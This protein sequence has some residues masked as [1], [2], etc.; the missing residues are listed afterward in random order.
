MGFNLHTCYEYYYAKQRINGSFFKNVKNIKN[1]GKVLIFFL[2][3]VI[4]YHHFI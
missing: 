2:D 3:I 1:T 4:L